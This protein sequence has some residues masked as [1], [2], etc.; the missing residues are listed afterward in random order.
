MSLRHASVLLLTMIVL[1]GIGACVEPISLEQPDQADIIAENERLFELE[2]FPYSSAFETVARSNA[3]GGTALMTILHD[4]PDDPTIDTELSFEAEPGVYELYVR[5]YYENPESDSLWAGI[6]GTVSMFNNIVPND[7]WTRTLIGTYE[8]NGTHRIS[9]GHR[10]NDTLLDAVI[11][12]RIGSLEPS[13]TTNGSLISTEY[14]SHAYYADVRAFPGAE[15]FG[16]NSK[17]ARGSDARIEFVTNLDPYGPG[18][19]HD[20]LESTGPR[21]VIP[22][23][24]GEINLESAA[25]LTDGRM[26]YAG[27]FMPDGEGIVLQRRQ[28][29][30]AGTGTVVYT[31]GAN[32][33]IFRYLKIYRGYG[34]YADPDCCGNAITL[35]RSDVYGNDIILDRFSLAFTTDNMVNSRGT[36]ITWQHGMFLYPLHRANHEKGAH[37]KGPLI[38]YSAKDISYHHNFQSTS[39]DRHPMLSSAK[40]TTDLRNNYNYNTLWG[41]TFRND[42]SGSAAQYNYVANRLEH[43]PLSSPARSYWA[44][45]KMK[46]KYT[47]NPSYP[48]VYLA[49]NENHRI[50][51]TD[52]QWQSIEYRSD[53]YVD[54]PS[55]ASTYRVSSAFDAPTIRETDAFTARDEILSSGGPSCVRDPNTGELR[56]VRDSLME[57]AITQAEQNTGFSS[58]VNGYGYENPFTAIDPDVPNGGIT[59]NAF[60]TEHFDPWRDANYPG[61]AWNDF[62]DSDGDGSEDY[63]LIEVYLN[64]WV[65]D[66]PSMSEEELALCG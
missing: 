2:D 12:R 21:Y 9:I 36:G 23:V 17:G 14:P 15:G 54:T 43:G 55:S 52:D 41:P 60:W 42:D 30:S 45:F 47:E 61:Y 4:R 3:S 59:E 65:P 27:Q 49:D 24:W 18:S 32:D 25:S 16:A 6:D 7:E 48:K 13:G 64:S 5:G 66:F 1:V 19:L 50:T 33:L 51:A 56:E 40:G 53:S 62:V 34:R 44:L 26:T 58:N 39:Q 11:L 22:L 63:Q 57:L 20:A 35:Y 29:G 31:R 28:S 38:G 37:G 8:L 46:T 10:E